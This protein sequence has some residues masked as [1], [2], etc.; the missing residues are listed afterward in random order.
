M[1]GINLGLNGQLY[2]GAG[3]SS[4]YTSGTLV[5]NCQDLT[6]KVEKSTAK[7]TTRA[8]NGWEAYVP[9]LRDATVS[10]K[11]VYDIGDANVLTIMNSFLANVAPT[12][13][14]EV[15][16]LDKDGFGLEGTMI[17]SAFSRNE[18]LEEAMTIDVEL[19]GGY[20]P[21]HPL[22]WTT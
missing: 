2:I 13:Q 1:A 21:T 18:P 4:G 8:N 11:M 9:A 10:F 5:G 12:N 16:V 14:L 3:G 19:K 20:D 22:N 17:C 7:V 6:L 15:A